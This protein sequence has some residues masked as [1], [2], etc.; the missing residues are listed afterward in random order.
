MGIKPLERTTFNF[1]INAGSGFP[2]TPWL[3][4]KEEYWRR[5]LTINAGR[6]PWTI[7]VDL[8]FEKGFDLAGVETKFVAKVLNLLDR[9]N[10]IVVE[11]VTGRTWDPGPF[12]SGSEDALKNPTHYDTPRRIYLGLSI[13]Y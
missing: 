11:P 8:R 12:Y 2:Y 7:Q 13:L 4:V 3:G 9:R 1:L 10:S 6:K 5:A